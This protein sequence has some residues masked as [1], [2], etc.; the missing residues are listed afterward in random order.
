MAFNRGCLAVRQSPA[1]SLR[2]SRGAYDQPDVALRSAS[3]GLG[4]GARSLVLP[5]SVPDRL[6]ADLG[7]QA[8]A[9]AFSHAPLSNAG[10]GPV[11][12]DAGKRPGRISLTFE[13]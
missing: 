13:S 4:S 6:F 2:G 5:P 10:S 8:E 3:A 11:P 7:R 1:Y 12:R 9:T